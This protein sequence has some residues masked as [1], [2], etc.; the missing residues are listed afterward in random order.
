MSIEVGID[1]QQKTNSSDGLRTPS[2][3]RAFQ[4]LLKQ[5]DSDM[6]TDI[7]YQEKI[8]LVS[9]EQ[10]SEITH[11]E[12][13]EN[14]NQEWLSKPGRKSKRDSVEEEVGG[15]QKKY[16]TND[17][18]KL[19]VYVSSKEKLPKQFGLAKLF[20]ELDIV[21]IIKVKYLSPY[22]IRVEFGNTA[23]MD[24][25]MFCDELIK[26][27]W[28]F[29]RAF[30]VSYTYGIIR[31]VDI[32]LS[33]ENIEKSIKCN[34]S[35]VLAS[36]FRLKRRGAGG[37]WI[38]SESVRLCFK[39]TYLP[40]HV[41]VDDLRIQVH[42]YVFPVT[43]CSKC[44]KLGHSHSRCK[45]DKIIC[46]KC[47]GNHANCDTKTFVC[48]NCQGNHISLNR[49]C[50]VFLKEKKIRELMAEFNVPYRIAYNMY[51][52]ESPSQRPTSQPKAPL[53][54]PIP[55]KPV[56]DVHT[57]NSFSLL[58]ERSTND[59]PTFAE[60]VRVQAEVHANR[61][62]NL[63]K[64]PESRNRNR[65]SD[66]KGSP[67]SKSPGMYYLSDLDSSDDFIKDNE[68]EKRG[69]SFTE[70][71]TKLKDI[72]FVKQL[73]FQDKIKLVIRRCLEWIILVAVDNIS[74]WPMLKLLLNYLDG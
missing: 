32:D 37:D 34:D 6:E 55:N 2:P 11:G 43:Q 4:S 66:T 70:L 57:H 39:G 17:E 8:K 29:H 63:R 3:S 61:S 42:P 30:A 41:Y 64:R 74:D 50:P 72:I 73:S 12:E 53:L 23:C 21:D 54:Q 13:A 59:K 69:V 9:Q 14:I 38:P 5:K 7:I 15:M 48:V 25:M 52:P 24:K 20:K 56:S 46:P 16:K 71:L 49:I 44:W 67:R 62:H 1:S 22:K 33:N 26:K 68:P 47:G 45:S 51:V 58:S 18:G 60:V 10:Q 35:A 27:G 19:E 31:D 28:I 65:V 40:S 36:A